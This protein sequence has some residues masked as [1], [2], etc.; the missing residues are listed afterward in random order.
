[1][2]YHFTLNII[3]WGNEEYTIPSFLEHEQTVHRGYCRTELFNSKKYELLTAMMV[4]Y[5]SI[6]IPRLDAIPNFYKDD[7]LIPLELY[8]ELI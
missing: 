4:D 6:R 5:N 2:T 8:K 1:M 7:E 3:Y